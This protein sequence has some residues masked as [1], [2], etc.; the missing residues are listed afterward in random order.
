MFARLKFLTR[1][2]YQNKTDLRFLKFNLNIVN[3][4]PF[5][6]RISLIIDKETW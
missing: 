3:Y 6:K 2:L 4:S 5:V 1:P